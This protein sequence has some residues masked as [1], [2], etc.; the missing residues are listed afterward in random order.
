MSDPRAVAGRLLSLAM[1][2][3]LPV[4]L[5]M[6]GVTYISAAARGQG[7]DFAPIAVA[8]RLVGT[9]NASLVYEHDPHAYN[10]VDNHEFREA[11][12]AIGFDGV[13]TPFVYPPLVAYAAVPLGRAS[14]GDLERVWGRV[15]LV[16]LIGAV[17]L[18][19]A[20]YLPGGSAAG[21]LAIVFAALCWFEPVQYGAWLGQ[22]TPLIFALMI[23]SMA[24]QR[25]GRFGSAGALLGLAAFIKLTPLLL[26][27]VWLWRG[28]RRAFIWCIASLAVLWAVSLAVC[29]FDL[30]VAYINR[31]VEAS[32]VTLIALNNH[33]LQAALMRVGRDSGS[34]DWTTYDT[35]LLLRLAIVG[36]SAALIFVGMRF[37]TR[38]PGHRPDI[39]RPAAE[40]LA[41]LVI[42]LVPNIAW[43][44]YFVLLLPVMATVLR[45][46]GTTS[47]VGLTLVSA[48][49]L[50]CARPILPAQELLPATGPHL[51]ASGPTWAALLLFLGITGAHVRSPRTSPNGSPGT[52]CN[53]ADPDHYLARFGTFAEREPSPTP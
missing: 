1:W 30:H 39:W 34:L 21:P 45:I 46:H 51:V 38:I 36:C 41:I 35:P 43:T 24:C 4:S 8:G 33:S 29:G 5:V 9:G 50:A 31:V 15:G 44:H 17:V 37:L 18:A 14:F 13:P 22:T 10:L 6:F 42:L 49:F 53:Q 2:I 25:R 20:V 28:P 16:L 19:V 23:G 26:A 52:R 32:Q 12:A 48:A 27:A 3:A 7:Y 40:S 47:K 11:A